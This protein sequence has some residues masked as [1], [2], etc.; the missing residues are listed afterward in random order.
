MSVSKKITRKQDYE[1]YRLA[2]EKLDQFRAQQLAV[3]ERV[4]QLESAI[5]DAQYSGRDLPVLLAAYSLAGG[6]PEVVA[7][8]KKKADEIRAMQSELSERQ[9]QCA[10]L[11]DAIALQESHVARADEEASRLVWE[12]LAPQHEEHAKRITK[13][14]RA[15]QEA[16]RGLSEWEAKA[17]AEA[18]VQLP[19][20]DLDFAGL[21]RQHDCFEVSQYVERLEAC[22][23]SV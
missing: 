2:V 5:V 10:V 16:F 1:P 17:Q 20:V 22:G 12:T 15:A 23:Y 14:L 3:A 13:A 9:N 8:E 11:S 7:A 21:T 6:D 4:G 19:I 18:D